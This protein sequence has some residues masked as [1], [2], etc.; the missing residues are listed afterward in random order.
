M[1]CVKS[2]CTRKCRI[3]N[4]NCIGCGRTLE[5]ISNWS[6]MSDKDKSDIVDRL[7]ANSLNVI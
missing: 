4:E 1:E 6:N 3:D 2:P 7:N 5:E